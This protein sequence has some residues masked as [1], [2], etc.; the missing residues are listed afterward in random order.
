MSFF[1]AAGE[2]V[3]PLAS[4]PIKS[5]EQYEKL[6]ARLTQTTFESIDREIGVFGVQTPVSSGSRCCGSNFRWRSLSATSIGEG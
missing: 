5:Y 3:K 2:L 6:R 1:K 4:A